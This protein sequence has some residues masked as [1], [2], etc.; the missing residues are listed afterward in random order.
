MRLIVGLYRAILTS[1][2]AAARCGMVNGTMYHAPWLI[3]QFA[4][5]YS[6][7]FN[8]L[9]CLCLFSMNLMI[10][11]DGVRV[12]RNKIQQPCLKEV[13]TYYTYYT[14]KLYPKHGNKKTLSIFCC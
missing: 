4:R 1:H 2:M 5:K 11:R 3:R 7:S 14:Y 9:R 6:V 10:L 8:S 13:E 12:T